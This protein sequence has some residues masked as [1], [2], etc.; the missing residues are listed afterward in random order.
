MSVIPTLPRIPH[1]P[2]TRDELLAIEATWSRLLVV[3]RLVAHIRYLHYALLAAEAE[4]ER[5]EEQA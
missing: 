5:G 2:L 4:L 3:T 1:E